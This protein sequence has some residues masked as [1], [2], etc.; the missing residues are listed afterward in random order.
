[1]LAEAERSSATYWC[2]FG[3]LIAVLV[4]AIWVV[5]RRRLNLFSLITIVIWGCICVMFYLYY[6][7][8]YS[9]TPWSKHPDP[10]S[11]ATNWF[12]GGGVCV[13]LAN[14]LSRI[15]NQLPRPIEPPEFPVQATQNEMRTEI[16]RDHENATATR[17]LFIVPAKI[18]R[19]PNCPMPAHLLGAVVP[20]FVAASDH[21]SAVKLAVGR[22][23]ADGYLLEDVV[24]GQ[25]QQLDPSSWAR[26]VEATWPEFQ[27]RMPSQAEVFNLL[28]TGGVFFGPFAGWDQEA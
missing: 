13:V 11:M 21:L 14:A 4:V 12:A 17:S 15:F 3:I 27:G 9:F 16:Q 20:C 23:Q 24:G 22:L 1:M 28:N 10:K 2:A 19:G 8:D 25:V 5:P 7:F 6:S 26:Y 18:R